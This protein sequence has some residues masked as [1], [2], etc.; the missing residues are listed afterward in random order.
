LDKV[1]EF[2]V[3]DDSTPNDI[4]NLLSAMEDKMDSSD[5]KPDYDYWE[6]KYSWE[7]IQNG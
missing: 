7:E 2:D 3:P 1:I 5:Y 4:N 6:S